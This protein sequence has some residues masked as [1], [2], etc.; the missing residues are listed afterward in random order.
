MALDVIRVELKAELKFCLNL[1]MIHE[2]T[3]V[4]CSYLFGYQRRRKVKGG[5]S[6]RFILDKRIIREGRAGRSQER[7]KESWQQSRIQTIDHSYLEDLV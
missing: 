3:C 1:A 2:S 5:L 6:A 4:K 7:P